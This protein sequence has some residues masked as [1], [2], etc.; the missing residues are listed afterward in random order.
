MRNGVLFLIGGLTLAACKPKESATPADTTLPTVSATA[1]PGPATA[2][3]V[4]RDALNRELGTLTLLESGT[5]IMI[6]G[7]LKGLP[8]GVH[9]IHIHTVGLC[10]PPT[11]ASAG[12]HWNPTARQHGKDNPQGQHLGDM[13]NL[14]VGADST[15][16]V[17]AHS[18]GGSFTGANALFDADGAAIVIHASP[19]DYKTDPAGAAG[20]RIACGVVAGSKTAN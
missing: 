6:T 3:A 18:E 10:E 1:T 4:I 19:D 14:T 12:S 5:G 8:P 2:T 13:L 17:N 20:D 9:A 15:V 16:S 7:D 11:F